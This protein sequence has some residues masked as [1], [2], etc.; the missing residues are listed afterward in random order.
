MFYINTMRFSVR[1]VIKLL[2]LVQDSSMEQ[3]PELF[4]RAKVQ[5][6]IRSTKFLPCFF[7]LKIF[8]TINAQMRNWAFVLNDFLN[9]SFS[10]RLICPLR[11]F[12]I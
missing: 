9:M 12:S 4:P 11:N 1:R 3:K 8:V 10:S 5:T 2:T 6:K 7:F